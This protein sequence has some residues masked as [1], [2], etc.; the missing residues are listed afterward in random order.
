[1]MPVAEGPL[2]R[3]LHVLL[4]HQD[5]RVRGSLALR[6]MEQLPGSSIDEAPDSRAA[7]RAL[8]SRRADLIVA[9]AAGLRSESQELAQI[10]RRN[11]VL[12]KKPLLLLG[13]ADEALWAHSDAFARVLDPQADKGAWVDCLLS[14]LGERATAG[15]LAA[16]SLPGGILI[17]SNGNA[18]RGPLAE[19]LLRKQLGFGFS[20]RS[21]GHKGLGLHPLAQ[22]AAQE[23]GL[24][25]GLHISRG[26]RDTELMG[27]AMTINL[28]F[29]EPGPMV[30]GRLKRL[31]WPTIDPLKGPPGDEFLLERIRAARDALARRVEKLVLELKAGALA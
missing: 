21:C 31:D 13:Q 22:M 3:T 2:S 19:A 24:D 23:L 11:P 18:I 15:P 7:V 16:A 12:A 17:L 4:L 1:M 25:L 14:L 8:S 9:P 26:L 29:G 27:L 20:V 10:L 28:C 30:P 6:L 5:D